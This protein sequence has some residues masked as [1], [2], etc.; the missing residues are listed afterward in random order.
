VE[1]RD[2]QEEIMKKLAIVGIVLSGVLMS[3]SMAQAKP[4]GMSNAE[5]QAL[6]IRSEGLNQKYGVG[7]KPQQAIIRS[8]LEEIG[9]WA[10]PSTSTVLVRPRI[11]AQ[12]AIIRG[13]REELQGLGA[14]RS[15]PTVLVRPRVAAQEAITRG[16][17]GELEGL[18]AVPSKP[19]A[20]D[21]SAGNGFD[22]NNAGIGAAFVLGAVLLGLASLVTR[23]RHHRPIAH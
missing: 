5:Y 8:K 2:R 13:R 9:A 22:W 4:V 20:R 12:Q 17:H 11:A 15:R 14:V 16:K 3:A 21:T 19:T 7:Q 10:V 1:Q 6:M 23:R 18:G